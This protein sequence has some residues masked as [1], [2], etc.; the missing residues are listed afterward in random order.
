LACQQIRRLTVCYAEGNDSSAL[1][2]CSN[3]CL[4]ILLCDNLFVVRVDLTSCSLFRSLLIIV[5][6]YLRAFPFFRA[7]LRNVLPS[8]V[9]EAPSSDPVTLSRALNKSYS[10]MECCGG[11]QHDPKSRYTSLGHKTGDTQT[12]VNLHKSG[13]HVLTAM[14]MKCSII[15][16][17][18]LYE[19]SPLETIRLSRLFC[20]LP[21]TSWFLACPV[22]RP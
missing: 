8:R 1:L 19:Y 16:D 11:Y 12:T 3:E 4:E 13:F 21:A 17:I 20:F 7:A 5:K 18:T 15:W 2:L 9:T 14:I 22:L 6:K 10:F